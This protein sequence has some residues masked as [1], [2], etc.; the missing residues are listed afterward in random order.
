MRDWRVFP[1][2]QPEDRLIQEFGRVGVG[3]GWRWQETAERGTGLRRSAGG[4]P[5]L[6]PRP[7]HYLHCLPPWLLLLCE[8]SPDVTGMSLSSSLRDALAGLVI[9]LGDADL[10]GAFGQVS[11]SGCLDQKP[12]SVAHCED[13]LGSHVYRASLRV[14]VEEVFRKCQQ[15]YPVSKQPFPPAFSSQY[16]P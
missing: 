2:I 13:S 9:S 6:L 12:P 3:V 4:F 1:H 10:Q 15:L 14:W 11:P 16:L 7:H 5:D 8:R